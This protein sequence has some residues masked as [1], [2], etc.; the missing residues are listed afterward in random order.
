MIA[1]RTLAAICAAI[2]LIV[3]TTRGLAQSDSIYR[4]VDVAAGRSKA[5]GIYGNLGKD[6]TPG[7]V[8]EVTVRTQP[9]HGTLVVRGS[10]AKM[11][12]TSRCPDVKVPIQAVLYQGK[13]N[14]TGPDEVIFE[15]RSPAGKVQQHVI[16][17][18]VAKGGAP[19][20]KPKGE[21]I[22]L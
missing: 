9:K 10:E 18:T 1:I 14:Y 2:G 3:P 17:I 13:L 7:A 20:R 19:A 11:K 15:V 5:L 4:N 8:P 6:C 22:D 16:K 12:P 21:S